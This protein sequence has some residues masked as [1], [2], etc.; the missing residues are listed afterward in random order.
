MKNAN[1]KKI[2]KQAKNVGEV[3]KGS[4]IAAKK[5]NKKITETINKKNTVKNKKKLGKKGNK[6]IT[7]LME[8]NEE[9]QTNFF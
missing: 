7:K 6:N 9:K 5:I 1:N 2:T 4:P 8:N 3:N